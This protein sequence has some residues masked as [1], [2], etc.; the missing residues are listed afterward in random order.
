MSVKDPEPFEFTVFV[1]ENGKPVPSIEVSAILRYANVLPHTE[2]Q[3]EYTDHTGH[4]H[5][6]MLRISEFDE[7]TLCV[8]FYEVGPYTTGDNH[9]YTI[10]LPSDDC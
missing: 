2:I 7:L 10:E 6:T 8:G 1:T 3:D 4:A 5:F 9:S